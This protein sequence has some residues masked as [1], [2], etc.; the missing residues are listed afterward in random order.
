LILRE[1]SAQNRRD[2][3]LKQYSTA[4]TTL[5]LADF[6]SRRGCTGLE[7]VFR[8]VS[9]AD[10]GVAARPGLLRARREGPRRSSA[11]EQQLVGA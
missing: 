11:A 9:G 5:I 2:S 3:G 10:P 8:P 4:K 7:A 6:S 1:K